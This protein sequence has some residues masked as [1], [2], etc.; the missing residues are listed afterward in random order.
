MTSGKDTTDIINA[1]ADLKQ[2]LDEADVS[3]NNRYV[4]MSQENFDLF[5]GY[6]ELTIQEQLELIDSGRFTVEGWE[7]P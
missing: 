2:A 5:C 3:H 1:L 4:Y 7:K 6:L